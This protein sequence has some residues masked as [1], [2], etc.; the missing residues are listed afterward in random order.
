ML[1]PMLVAHLRDMSERLH[2][3][4]GESRRQWEE[5]SQRMEQRLQRLQELRSTRVRLE[6]DRIV[7]LQFARTLSKRSLVE[8]LRSW[9]QG[10]P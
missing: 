6:Q 1:D 3:E 7:R 5:R 4:A 2:R 8:R 10:G 9:W